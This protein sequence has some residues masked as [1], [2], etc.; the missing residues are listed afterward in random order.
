MP[1]GDHILD[2]SQREHVHRQHRF[3]YRSGLFQFRNLSN[4]SDTAQTSVIE[5][6]KM[7]VWPS[8]GHPITQREQGTIQQA[9]V[10]E[11]AE[12]LDKKEAASSHTCNTFSTHPW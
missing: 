8:L 11:V 4:C 9:L 6:S 1:W 10:T 7:A 2:I 5:A 3:Y 12:G